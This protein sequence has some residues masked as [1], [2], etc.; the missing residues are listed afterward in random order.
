VQIAEALGPGSVSTG[1]RRQN[2]NPEVVAAIDMIENEG[3]ARHKGKE[4]SKVQQ[5]RKRYEEL[6]TAEPY[7]K[8]SNSSFL[9][10]EAAGYLNELIKQKTS[11]ADLE[12]V[13]AG[14]HSENIPKPK[15]KRKEKF[16]SRYKKRRRH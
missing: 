1:K 8:F 4:L 9:T 2:K 11:R 16:T 13:Y 15:F 10:P 14:Q 5:Y 6:K 3:G 12:I 7:K